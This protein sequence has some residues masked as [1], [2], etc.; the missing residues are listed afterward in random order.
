MS[1]AFDRESQRQNSGMNPNFIQV[2][3]VKDN[4]DPQKMGRLKVWLIGSSAAED[5][6]NSWITCNYSTPFGGRTQGSPN[7]D[8]YDE[9]PKSYGFWAVPPDVGTR[10]FVFFINGNIES[11]YWFG[12]A[13]DH[14]MNHQV[15]GPHTKVMGES[16]LETR[17]PVTEFDRNTPSA[18]P[19]AQFPNVPLIDSLQRQNLLYDP[20]NGTPD[21]SARR[22]I[23]STVYG[24]TSPRGN[25]IVLDD[26]YTQDE[27]NA[28]GWDDDAD[29]IQN[30]EY[31]NPT[32]DTR[33]GQRTN[34]GIVLRT[35]SGA[36]ILISE[37]EGHIFVINRDGTA[38]IEM[39]AD[40]N[41]TATSDKDISLRAKQDIN[42]YAERN[43]NI[44]VLGNMN[45]KVH[46]NSKTEILGNREL[47]LTGNDTT[48]ITEGNR[49]LTLDTGSLTVKVQD[50]T[51][52]HS[53]GNTDIKTNAEFKLRADSNADINTNANLTVSSTG[54]TTVK[55]ANITQSASVIGLNGSSSVNLTGG[56]GNLT[57]S[58]NTHVSA[59]LLAGADVRTA[60]V[61]LNNHNHIYSK[62]NV[63]PVPTT[64]AQGGGSGESSSAAGTAN[65]AQTAVDVDKIEVPVFEPIAYQDVVD[66]NPDNK[67]NEKVL[68]NIEQVRDKSLSALGWV[69][70]VSGTVNPDGY[71]GSASVNGLEVSGTGWNIETSENSNVV[72]PENGYVREVSDVHIVIDHQNGFM[73][74]IRNLT[75]T[76]VERGATVTKGQLIG[77]T[78]KTTLFEIRRSG[79]SLFG[80]EGT[81]DPG[82]FYIESTGTGKAA[83]NASLTENEA[84]SELA[85]QAEPVA[86]SSEVVKLIEITSILSRLPTSGYLQ[87]PIAKNYEAPIKQKAKNSTV[88]LPQDKP[89][90]TPT[91]SEV[92]EWVVTE[93][94]GDLLS[95]VKQNEGSLEYQEHIGFYRSGRF[96]VYQDSRGFDTIG[97]G[98]LV[99]RNENFSSGLTEAQA[100]LLLQRDLSSAVLEARSIAAQ[101]DMVIPRDAQKVLV[102]MVFQLGK[103][104]TLA[105][106]KMLAALAANN[107]NLAA[108]EMIDSQW[109]RQTPNRVQFHVDRLRNL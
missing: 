26:G 39:D 60:K 82:L 33:V 15:P 92:S 84:S 8:S 88:D 5:N 28:P 74:V 77:S 21:R 79:S 16:E 108:D 80:F 3:I 23:T 44:E 104:G 4:R 30:T 103:K 37:T 51:S 32:G 93:Q 6:N 18:D 70:P 1:N 63:G 29:D 20:I 50:V 71:W 101:Y 10:V 62:S 45:T 73:T 11:A 27:L 99:R 57:V 89:I 49:H 66:V 69:M 43:M 58:G 19:N 86:E 106:K 75:S 17:Y 40:G 90:T 59:S 94:D 46:G 100:D 12:C 61:S 105:F 36:Q 9:F 7:A 48:N 56:G 97:Y 22:Q 42:Y 35:R 65:D 95:E 2:G 14:H 53:V 31:G 55:A 64:P 25:H 87:K 34:E 24:M 85:K 98:H 13:Y 41:I 81:I 47:L 109:Y 102:E 83:A 96:W 38:R 107:Y 78:F 52:V 72:S 68:A 91:V 54:D 67:V 76:T